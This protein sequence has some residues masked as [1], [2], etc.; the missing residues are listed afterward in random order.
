MD[1]YKKSDILLALATVFLLFW[2]LGERGLWT[3]EGRWAEVTREML[4]TR[5]FFHPT[6]NGAPYFDKPLLTYW[7]IALI[8]PLT[9]GLNEWTIRIPSA[10]SGLLAI[11]AT[12]SIGRRLWSDRVGKTAG[13]ILLS[14]YGFL[15]WARTGTADMENLAAITL[16]LAWYWSRRD[17]PKFSTFLVFYLIAFVGSLTKGLTALVVPILVVLPDVFT[18]GRWKK[19]LRPSHLLAVV[20]AGS[21]YLIPFVYAS[22]TRGG[23][24]ENGLA[25]VFHENIQRYIHP[26][27]H[28]GPFYCYLYYIPILFLPW[29]PLFLAACTGTVRKWKKLDSN[30]RWLIEA[31]L[32]VFLF[33]SVSG[34]RRSYYILPILPLCALWT[35]VFLE[36]DIAIRHWGIRIQVGVLTALVLLEV[37]SPLIWPVL[38]KCTGFVPPNG[39]RIATLLSGLAVP[40]S[41]VISLW[42]TDRVSAILGTNRPVAPLVA[43]ML[44]IMGILF[45][46]Q[47]ETLGTYRTERPFALELKHKFAGTCPENVAFFHKVSTN[48]IFYLDFPRPVRLLPDQDAVRRFIEDRSVTRVLISRRRYLPKLASVLP[49][50]MLERPDLTEDIYPWEKTSKKLVAWDLEKAY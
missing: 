27:D 18:G 7:I 11:W 30:T 23:Y 47:T 6:I 1:R 16:A 41:L 14:T 8:S 28:R 13:W 33:F 35:A 37:M 39:L 5:D 12:V 40:G 26:F 17:R 15:F 24:Q 38:E 45:C 44:V 9:R 42:R 4:I 50:S 29:T 49:A 3:S 31:F 43:S 48:V 46:W 19:V 22:I 25:M 10:I 34:S 2:A 21:I 36:K 32:I 20:L